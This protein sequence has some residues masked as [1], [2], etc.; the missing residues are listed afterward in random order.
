LATQRLTAETKLRRSVPSSDRYS[1]LIY[2]ALK[3]ALMSFNVVIANQNNLGTWL[4]RVA[5]RAASLVDQQVSPAKM[6]DYR[7]D[8]HF[9]TTVA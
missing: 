2:I 3:Q 4:G 5:F 9:N 1:A 6:T 8:L 7:F